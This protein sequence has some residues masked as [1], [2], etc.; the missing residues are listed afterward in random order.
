MKIVAVFALAFAM[1]LP[2]I[3]RAQEASETAVYVSSKTDDVTGTRLAYA[4]RQQLR[5][6]KTLKLVDFDDDSFMQ[7][8]LVT[9]DPNSDGAETVYSAVITAH[10]LNSE[11]TQVF[12]TNFVGVCGSERLTACANSL[13]AEIDKWS[14][15]IRSELLR[16]LRDLRKG[17]KGDGGN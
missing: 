17:R 9:I 2:A 10:Q 11:S 14:A 16:V 4:L 7:V 5:S 13:A 6:S 8:H 15:G 1:T 3:T 12:L